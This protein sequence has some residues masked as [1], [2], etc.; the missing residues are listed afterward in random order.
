MSTSS[1]FK[2]LFEA[3][4]RLSVEPKTMLALMVLDELGLANIS[5]EKLML[6]ELE[7]QSSQTSGEKQQSTVWNPRCR[8]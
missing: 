6:H 7:R 5:P 2:A 3:A 1:G 8:I 4:Q